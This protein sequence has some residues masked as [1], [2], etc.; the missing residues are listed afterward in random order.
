ME[1][2]VEKIKHNKENEEIFTKLNPDNLFDPRDDF[3]ETTNKIKKQYKKDFD[4]FSYH[5]KNGF[6][7]LSM[8]I[9]K[10]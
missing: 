10:S 9:I 3:F 4:S 7:I 8:K 1:F 5:H 6:F 2:D